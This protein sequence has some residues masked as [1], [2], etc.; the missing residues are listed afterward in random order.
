VAED[1]EKSLLTRVWWN[2]LQYFNPSCAESYCWSQQDRQARDKEPSRIVSVKSM[3][4]EI[5]MCGL[6]KVANMP[7]DRRVH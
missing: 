1:G 4:V 2:L 6:T 3:A 7:A 5:E